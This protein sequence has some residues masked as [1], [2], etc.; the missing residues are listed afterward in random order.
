MEVNDVVQEATVAIQFVFPTRAPE[1][2]EPFGPFMQ[3]LA[4]GAA[5]DG[6][7][8]PLVI[9]SHGSGGTPWTHRDLASHLAHSGFVTA[10]VQHPGNTRA[11]DRLAGQAVNLANRPRHVCLAIDAAFT[12]GVVGK[13]LSRQGVFV[14][15]HSMGGY[16]ALAVAGGN[17]WAAT[18]ETPDGTAGPV[19]VEHDARVR[20]LVLLA[21]ATPWFMAEGAL[22]D[23]TVPILMRTGERDSLTDASHALIVERGIP[24]PSRLDHQV[25][26]NAGHFSFLSAY[27][28]AMT[29]PAI[30]P[31]QDPEGFDRAAYLPIL[32]SEI[33][34]FLRRVSTG[35]AAG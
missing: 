29:S 26:P 28:P 14:I 2:L 15:G 34:A 17:P 13:H 11:D 31:S 32:F 27:P 9:I 6:D 33:V 8:L 7:D 5:V 21:P 35:P 4:L 23:V 1:R 22:A 10:L 25:V 20:A 24:D 12:D 3:S 16:T 30:L 19:A 18:W